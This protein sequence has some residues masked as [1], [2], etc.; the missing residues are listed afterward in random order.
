MLFI[1]LE[2]FPANIVSN[3][4]KVLQIP[5][6]LNHKAQIP[7]KIGFKSLRGPGTVTIW[8]LDAP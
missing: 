5:H 3:H 1:L 8:N 6:N 2:P 4:F 7:L